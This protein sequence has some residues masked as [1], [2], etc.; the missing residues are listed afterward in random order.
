MAVVV[1]IAGINAEKEA[2][3]LGGTVSGILIFSP[4]RVSSQRRRY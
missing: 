2:E 1:M 3:T 4:G